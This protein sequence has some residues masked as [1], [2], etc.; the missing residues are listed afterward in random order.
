MNSWRARY[1]AARREAG[2]QDFAVFNFRFGNASPQVMN[3]VLRA[4]ARVSTV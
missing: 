2:L 3:D 1:L 4:A